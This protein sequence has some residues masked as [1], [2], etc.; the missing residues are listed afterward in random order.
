MGDI[1]YWLGFAGVLEGLMVNAEVFDFGPTGVKEVG[2][3]VKHT[4]VHMTR[5]RD[6]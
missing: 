5:N 3:T 1:T 2:K 4:E 6:T